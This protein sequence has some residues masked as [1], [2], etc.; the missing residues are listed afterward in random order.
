MCGG[1]LKEWEAREK[2][3]INNSSL[4]TSSSLTLSSFPHESQVDRVDAILDY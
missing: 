3:I 4:P 1:S 2:R